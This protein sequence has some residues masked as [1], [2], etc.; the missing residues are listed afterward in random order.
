[1]ILLKLISYDV[2][3]TILPFI[4]DA[5]SNFAVSL[6]HLRFLPEAQGQTCLDATRVG[7][8]YLPFLHVLKSFSK[9]DRVGMS[10]KDL[11]VSRPSKIQY[12]FEEEGIFQLTIHQHLSPNSL[13]FFLRYWMLFD[14]QNAILCPL[15]CRIYHHLRINAFIFFTKLLVSCIQ[16]FAFQTETASLS[17]IILSYSY[18]E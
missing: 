18:K 10:S 5:V 1:M 13:V 8:I 3:D 15:S 9:I 4:T 16:T 11:L 14:E 7:V 17:V 6:V 2:Y 12:F